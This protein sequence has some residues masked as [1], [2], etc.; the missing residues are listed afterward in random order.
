MQGSG[1]SCFYQ[2]QLRQTYH[3]QVIH[4][5]G[6][7]RPDIGGLAGEL[8]G[9]NTLA[10]VQLLDCCHHRIHCIKEQSGGELQ[11]ERGEEEGDYIMHLDTHT[12]TD[13]HRLTWKAAVSV[14]YR[15]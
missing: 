14:T 2:V 8:R 11:R 1:Q 12:H 10:T 15:W 4:K 3:P 5:A 7:V 9:T 13:K 6:A